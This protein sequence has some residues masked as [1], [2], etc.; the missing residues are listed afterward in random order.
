MA[1]MF[2]ALKSRFRSVSNRRVHINNDLWPYERQKI[3]VNQKS[4]RTKKTRFWIRKSYYTLSY[5]VQV[6]KRI[7]ASMCFPSRG[8]IS[9]RRARS[10]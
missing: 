10:V 9:E 3:D 2:P 7:H 6:L 8:E 4:K 5:I 1:L